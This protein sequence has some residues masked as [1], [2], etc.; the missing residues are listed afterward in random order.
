MII[1]KIKINNFKCLK[2]L[3]TELPGIFIITGANSSGKSSFIYAILSILQSVGYPLNLELNGDYINLGDFKEVVYNHDI[4][5]NLFLEIAFRQDNILSTISAEYEY[6]A[7]K[8]ASLKKFS[9]SN[10]FI[11]LTLFK[12]NNKYILEGNYDPEKDPLIDIYKSEDFIKFMNLMEELGKSDKETLP[13]LLSDLNKLHNFR[14]SFRGLNE[15]K[16]KLNENIFTSM[17]IDYIFTIPRSFKKTFNFVGP[18]RYPPE[19]TYYKKSK[20]NLKLNAYGENYVDQLLDWYEKKSKKYK[21]INDELKHLEL[22]EDLRFKKFQGGRFEIRIKTPL[23]NSFS[24]ISDIGL[25]VSQFLPVLIADSQLPDNSTL[26]VSQPEIHLH[27]SAQAKYANLIAENLK[28]YNKRYIIETHSEYLINRFRLLI[29]R[30]ELEENNIKI[31]HL[32]NSINGSVPFEIKLEKNGKI[33]GAPEDFFETYQ[34][35]TLD[36]AIAAVE[37]D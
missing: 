1:E 28:K 23:I 30:G 12:E 37:N 32:V 7:K 20:S 9:I 11:Q 24:N 5:N 14:Y 33:E 25:G 8:I 10:E 18:F 34:I 29:A 19:R 2:E 26:A 17:K 22:I 15:M 16:K 4:N 13:I 6:S 35:D 21:R 36:L 31:I 27:P 3:E